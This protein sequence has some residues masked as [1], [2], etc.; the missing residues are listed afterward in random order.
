MQRAVVSFPQISQD[1]Q[2]GVR[3]QVTLA[4]TLGPLWCRKPLFNL[5]P[6]ISDATDMPRSEQDDTNPIQRLA[7]N[8]NWSQFYDMSMNIEQRLPNFDYMLMAMN[9]YAFPR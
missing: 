2:A 6:E 3:Y 8:I 7:D 5:H 4:G 9:D 1:Y